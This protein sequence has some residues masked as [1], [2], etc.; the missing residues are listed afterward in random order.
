MRRTPEP[1]EDSPSSF[2]RPSWA[3]LCTCVPPHS[4]LEKSPMV[5]TRTRSPY[6][7]PNSAMAP[8]FFAS[9]MPMISAWTSSS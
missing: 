5:T 2:T 7:S 8:C 6:F 1:M 3:V 9:S 4:S